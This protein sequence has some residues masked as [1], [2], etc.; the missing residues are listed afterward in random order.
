[1][2]YSTNITPKTNIKIVC[3]CITFGAPGAE[4][5][6]VHD[7]SDCRSILD[8]FASHGHTELD[9][10]RMYGMGSSE[11]YLRQLGYTT[12]SSSHSFLIATKCYPSARKPNTPAKDKYTFSAPDITR[13][14]GNSLSILGT[15][16]FDLFYVY[17]PDR[18]TELEETLHAPRLF[19]VPSANTESHTTHTTRGAFPPQW[20]H[21]LVTVIAK[22]GHG[23]PSLPSS[24][25]PISL[26]CVASKIAESV[27]KTLLQWELE[28]RGLLR[29]QYNT[30]PGIS[31]THAVVHL[32]HRGRDA[33][34]E[35]K[36]VALISIDVGGA[37]NQIEHS[38]LV[39]RLLDLN[40]PDIAHWIRLWLLLHPDRN[41][42]Q[43]IHL[44]DVSL[45]LLQSP[46]QSISPRMKLLKIHRGLF[47]GTHSSPNSQPEAGSRF[48]RTHAQGQMYRARYWQQHYF[49]ALDLIRPVAEKH[50]LGLPEVA[51][52]WTMY[53][54]EL[55]KKHGD[56]VIIGASST[57]YIEQNLKD[58]EKGPLPEEVVRKVDEAWKIV[59]PN[60]PPYYH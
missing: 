20:K 8:I 60:A 43:Q 16:S 49:D 26:L 9:T 24:Y 17:S 57:K 30:V 39:K 10:A 4:Q 6:R 59:E 21:A 45:I 58:F 35:G 36:Q 19:S 32:V 50:G 15:D 11:D 22:P 55:N 38:A 31:T 3:G 23:N 34:A 47:I 53:H 13:S 40:L 28:R 52:R 51:L 46:L 7:L 33:V 37:F 41:L 29:D 56:A 5:A 27:I 42:S 12:P 44:D 25:R 18:E 14:I 48:D 2:S 54:S 1:M